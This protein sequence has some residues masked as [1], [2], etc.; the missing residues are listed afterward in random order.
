MECSLRP[1]GGGDSIKLQ[2]SWNESA[3]SEEL[4]MW[5]F[6]D[7]TMSYAC[8]VKCA[9]ENSPDLRYFFAFF[10]PSTPI[11]RHRLFC[12]NDFHLFWVLAVFVWFLRTSF[13]AGLAGIGGLESG[14]PI[15]FGPK[16]HQL[17]TCF[18]LILP[19]HTSG[20]FLLFVELLSSCCFINSILT[21]SFNSLLSLDVKLFCP[22]S[23]GSSF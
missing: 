12:I 21:S 8:Y 6:R 17:F 22:S 2:F 10:L 16:L 19:P 11:N 7:T 23:H 3:V 13:V 20:F 9:R 1:E 4:F 18:W 14:G 5:L 15:K